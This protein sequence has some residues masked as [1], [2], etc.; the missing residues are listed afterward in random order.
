MSA[1]DAIG[2]VEFKGPKY[3]FY[4]VTWLQASENFSHYKE[5]W[6]GMLGIGDYG[7]WLSLKMNYQDHLEHYS[8][9]ESEV[10]VHLS[11]KHKNLK[12]AIAKAQ[13]GYLP[14]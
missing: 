7:C 11:E 5:L 10:L 3:T 8:L 14:N 13:K 2:V 12:A 6:N 9:Q 1:D 4:G